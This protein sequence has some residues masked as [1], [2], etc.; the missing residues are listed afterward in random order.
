MGNIDRRLSGTLLERLFYF[1]G[2]LHF[3]YNLTPLF[4]KLDKLGI[5]K[6]K[7]TNKKH[8]FIN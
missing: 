2:R 1:W 8:Y 6:I 4:P 7:I 5:K 3:E